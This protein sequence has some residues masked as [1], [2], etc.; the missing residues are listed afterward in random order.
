[1]CSRSCAVNLLKI[2]SGQD[3]QA[4]VLGRLAPVQRRAYQQVFSLL[5]ECSSDRVAT[6]ALID[7]VLVR[8][9]TGTKKKAVRLPMKGPTARWR[10]FLVSFRTRSTA[11]AKLSKICC[12]AGSPLRRSSRSSS[13]MVTS[14]SV[15]AW[16]DLHS[17]LVVQ[18]LHQLTSLLRLRN[19]P[20][21]NPAAE[22]L[23]E[24]ATVVH[25]FR[26]FLPW[27]HSACSLCRTPRTSSSSDL[28]F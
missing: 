24:F 25:P 15:V 7:Q 19:F 14:K 13:G 9:A 22:L 26:I 28:G 18:R 27:E 10:L 4:K 3:A 21:G 20:L 2:K 17:I 5:Y 1:M 6:K 8:L 16:S 12:L 23:F 11:A